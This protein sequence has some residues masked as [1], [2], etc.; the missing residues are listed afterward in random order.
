MNWSISSP[1]K[2]DLLEPGK[3]KWN[4]GREL[5]GAGHTRRPNPAGHWKGRGANEPT[6][7]EERTPKTIT[8]TKTSTIY[9]TPTLSYIET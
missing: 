2:R 6:Y 3:M 5:G 8:A 4:E 1:K 9:C 7:N